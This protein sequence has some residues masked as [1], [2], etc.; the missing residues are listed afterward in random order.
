MEDMIKG[1]YMKCL[2]AC[3][4]T[5]N[6]PPDKVLAIFRTPAAGFLLLKLYELHVCQD[7]EVEFALPYMAMA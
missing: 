4:V 6:K 3:E 1:R 7:R 2:A 5:T